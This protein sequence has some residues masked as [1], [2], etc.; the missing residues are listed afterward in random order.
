MKFFNLFLKSNFPFHYW[1]YPDGDLGILEP[2]PLL[3]Y[4]YSTH[5]ILPPRSVGPN[6]SFPIPEI[7]AAVSEMSF[8]STSSQVH[9]CSEKV[10]ILRE[11]AHDL[12]LRLPSVSVHSR[13]YIS[14]QLNLDSEP[15]RLL[16]IHGS[17]TSS[18]TRN[19]RSTDLQNESQSCMFPFC[20]SMKFIETKVPAM[21][22]QGCNQFL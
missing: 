10:D 6:T 17:D 21:E 14:V 2:S 12:Y 19:V 5:H 8:P 22:L 7:L 1:A 16:S 15:V 20:K 4:R 3:C 9:L 13:C 18:P 11:Y